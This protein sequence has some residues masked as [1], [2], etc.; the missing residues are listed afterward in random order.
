M[1]YLPHDV[2]CSVCPSNDIITADADTPDELDERDWIW[3]V[4]LCG[5]AG[6]TG[7]RWLGVEV[8]RTDKL[9]DIS[10]IPSH[11]IRRAGVLP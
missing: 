9:Y 8:D 2:P 6:C 3:Y 11:I 5:C 4:G 7:R 10:S 1:H